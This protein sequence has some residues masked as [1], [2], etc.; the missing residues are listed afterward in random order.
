MHIYIVWNKRKKIRGTESARKLVEV[1]R[2][3]IWNINKKQTGGY[4]KPFSYIKIQFENNI[5]LIWNQSLKILKFYICKRT[6]ILK[7]VVK[8]SD[9]SFWSFSFSFSLYNFPYLNAKTKQNK[10][11]NKTEQKNKT[12]QEKKLPPVETASHH[13]QSNTESLSAKKAFFPFPLASSKNVIADPETST[14]INIIYI[15]LVEEIKL[16]RPLETS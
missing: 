16:I 2:F 4:I 11:K 15:A 1:S 3:Y 5:K 8:P 6:K 7:Y 14:H 10:T 13:P 12:K 9:S